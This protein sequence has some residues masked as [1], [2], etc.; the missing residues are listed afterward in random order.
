MEKSNDNEQEK[1]LDSQEA[2]LM[3]ITNKTQ[4]IELSFVGNQVVDKKK[5]LF[6]GNYLWGKRRNVITPDIGSYIPSRMKAACHV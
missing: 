1:G 5:I 3:M 2:V 6:G 4:L